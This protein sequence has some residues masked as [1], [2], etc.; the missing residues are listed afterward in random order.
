MTVFECAQMFIQMMLFGMRPTPDSMHHYNLCIDTPWLC[1]EPASRSNPVS[2]FFFYLHSACSRSLHV[3]DS[4]AAKL[5]D[6]D[7]KR[8]RHPTC[9]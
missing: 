1:S 5:V 9:S 6:A 3:V 8:T 7:P 2:L 4:D